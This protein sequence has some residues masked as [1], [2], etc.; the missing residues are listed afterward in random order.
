MEYEENTA[1]KLDLFV[2]LEDFL[3][4]AKRMWL[5]AL[6]LVS[7]CAAG[8]TGYRYVNYRP[9]YA[10]TASFTVR[11]ANPLYASVSGYN[12]QTAEQLA[13]TFPYI[14]T[15]NVLQT[16]VKNELGISAM[17]GISVSASAGSSIITL[18]I[19]D[20]DPQRAYDVLNAV[21]KYYPELAEFVVGPTEMTLLDESGLPTQPINPFDFKSQAVKG[22]LIGAVLWC[23]LVLFLALNKNTIRNEEEL[24]RVLNVPCLGLLPDVKV[25]SKEVCPLIYKGKKSPGFTEGIRLLCL[26]VEKAMEEEKKKVL[27]VSSAIPGEGKTTV[28]VNLAITLAKKGKRVLLIDCDLRNPSVARA[29]HLSSSNSLVE[30]LRGKVTVRDVILPTEIENLS[31]ICGGPGGKS[32]AA[33]MLSQER[34]ARLIQASKNLFDYVILDTPPCSL[35]ADAAEMAGLADCGLI[36][37]RQ[38]LASRD[39]ILDGVQRLGDGALPMIGCAFNGIRKTLSGGYGYGYGYGYGGYGGY[40]Y[41]N[42]K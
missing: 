35:L 20:S 37:I 26:R 7:V 33:E 3:K 2:L 36:V 41:G 12:S 27:L 14:V 30:Y 25:P 42:K 16:R 17:P 28:S 8:L 11:V 31:V 4:E 19:T 15:N 38:D 10:A 18:K 1:Q 29:L 21:M 39:E 40:G 9:S 13:K 22:A 32:G 6:V 5:L 34:T 24:K 23:A